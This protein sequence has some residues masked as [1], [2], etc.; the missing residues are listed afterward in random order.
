MHVAVAAA[1][2]AGG[3]GLGQATITAAS[4]AP[5]DKPVARTV[6]RYLSLVPDSG[7]QEIH[8][9]DIGNVTVTSQLEATTYPTAPDGIGLGG[10]IGAMV[11]NGPNVVVFTMPPSGG[12]DSVTFNSFWLQPA[13]EEGDRDPVFGAGE[14]INEEGNRAMVFPFALLEYEGTSVSGFYGFSARVNTTEQVVEVII[15][16]QLNG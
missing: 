15:T 2:V 5:K 1:G 10:A 12:P 14:I 7:P 9:I 3:L 4:A 16:V 13:G 6:A 11:N 8:V